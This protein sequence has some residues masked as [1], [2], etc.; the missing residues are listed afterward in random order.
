MPKLEISKI[1]DA[2]AAGGECP[3]CT[4]MN[5]ANQRYVSSFRGM[6]VM[7]P[8][9]RV[10]TNKTGFCPQ[11]YEELYR[12]E[13]KLGLSLMVHTHIH[14]ALPWLRKQLTQA[15]SL[16]DTTPE[17]QWKRWIRRLLRAGTD[18]SAL[19]TLASS[20]TQFLNRCYICDLLSGDLDRYTFT[21]LY[22]WQHDPEFLPTLRNSKGFCLSHFAALL[23]QAR[24]TLSTSRQSQWLQ[25]IVPLMI[26]NLERLERE[27]YAFT[28]MYHH[29]DTHQP[30]EA[31]QSALK[32]TLQKMCGRLMQ[33]E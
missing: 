20:L 32:R 24:R 33:L 16:K 30:T 18:S 9:V 6:R 28:Q 3:L 8:E 11:H 27:V 21:V 31:E 17:H 19:N 1:H 15:T 12:G 14:Y 13:G 5:E 23:E 2:Y 22:L 10:Q 26:E 4:V 7:A 29:T 25:V